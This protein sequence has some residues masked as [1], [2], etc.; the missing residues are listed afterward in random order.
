MY[1]VQEQFVDLG[2]RIHPLKPYSK[3]PCFKE[4][5][6]LEVTKSD[7]PRI[8]GKTRNNTGMICDGITV[9]DFDTGLT[10]SREWYTQHREILKTIVITR[11]GIHAYFK[12]SGEEWHGKHSEGDIRC[13][14]KGYVVVPDSLVTHDDGE[15]WLYSFVD[16]HEL[17]HPDE[18]PLFRAEY[19]K[20]IQKTQPSRKE[21]AN[22][23]AYISKIES[24][25]RKNGSAGLVRAAAKCRDAGL[26]ESETTI[27]LIHWNQG[28]TV[29][30]PWSEPEI[31]RAV[32]RIYGE[33]K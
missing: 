28:P 17:C 30:P 4:W 2:Y 15:S 23:R 33:S 26:S 31:A 19:V 13:H 12:S 21:I 25:E 3:K 20:R 29:N 1:I 27:E 9:V 10:K 18:L 5:Q 7:I 8:W 16:G 32:T 14:G 22:I 11:K 24:I 6:K